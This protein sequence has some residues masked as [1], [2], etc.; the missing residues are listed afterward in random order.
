MT[1]NTANIRSI[2]YHSDSFV[3]TTQRGGRAGGLHQFHDGFR[4][5]TKEKAKPLHASS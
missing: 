2:R 3:G 1:A 4:L 5:G